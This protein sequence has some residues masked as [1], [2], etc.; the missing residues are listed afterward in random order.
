MKGVS[1]ASDIWALGAV[2][3]HM[4]V[5]EPLHQVD[6]SDETFVD[7]SAE[8]LTPAEDDFW[9]KALPM[10][11][12]SQLKEIVRSML[13]IDRD[14]RPRADELSTAIDRGMRIWRQDTEDGRRFIAKGEHI[15]GPKEQW[16]T[17]TRAQVPAGIL[18]F[19]TSW[20]G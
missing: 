11:F 9:V 10:H 6:L 1:A 20:P 12:T 18:D 17:T 14:Q 2:L 19:G 3:Y 16:K 8:T 7:L 15:L 4:M 13:L 5:G